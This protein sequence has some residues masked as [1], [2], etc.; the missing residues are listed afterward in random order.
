[1]V[2]EFNL[3]GIHNDSKCLAVHVRRDYDKSN[4]RDDAH[5]YVTILAQKTSD[6]GEWMIVRVEFG[7]R[8]EDEVTRKRAKRQ[9]LP[10]R[11]S[12]CFRVQALKW[13]QSAC[14]TPIMAILMARQVS[15]LSTCS[16]TLA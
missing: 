14:T 1:M 13:P 6:S 8:N 16:D 2:N 10:E 9:D 3:V 4:P 11:T 5:E 7:Q 15:S 12:R